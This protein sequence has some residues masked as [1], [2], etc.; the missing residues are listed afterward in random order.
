[1]NY[2]IADTVIGKEEAKRKAKGFRDRGDKAKIKKDKYGFY[3]V[4]VKDTPQRRQSIINNRNKYRISPK[5]PRL[6]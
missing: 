5:P 1:M 6:R 4:L 2:R 3:Q